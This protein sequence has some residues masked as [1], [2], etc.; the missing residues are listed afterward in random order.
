MLSKSIQNLLF[1]GLSKYQIR[2][3][4]ECAVQL[5]TS[6]LRFGVGCTKEVGQDLVGLKAKKVGVLTDF[7]L[8]NLPPVQIVLDSIAKEGIDVSLYPVVQVFVMFLL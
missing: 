3:I 5:G 1:V 6:N 2:S 7:N 4:S 8:V